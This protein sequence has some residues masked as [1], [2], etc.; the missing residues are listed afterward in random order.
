[1]CL[2]LTGRVIQYFADKPSADSFMAALEQALELPQF[3]TAVQSSDLQHGDIV[4]VDCQLGRHYAVFDKV[5]NEVIHYQGAPTSSGLGGVLQITNLLIAS[6]SNGVDGGVVCE[7]ADQFFASRKA[8]KR[9]TY[10][11]PDQPEVRSR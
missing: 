2:R 6:P 3:E 1:V 4:S 7:A 9:V 5:R 11:M 8:L 10:L